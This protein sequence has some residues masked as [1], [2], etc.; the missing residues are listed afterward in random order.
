MKEQL[1]NKLRLQKEIVLCE[2]DP[3]YFMSTYVHCTH[4]THGTALFVPQDFQ[5]DYIST[6]AAEESDFLVSAA[7]QTGSSLSS[8]LYMFWRAFFNK[9][10]SISFT[11]QNLNHSYDNIQKIRHAYRCMPAWMRDTN[12][13]VVDNKG[14]LEFANGSKI[15]VHSSNPC[16]YRG[17]NL[18]AA[19]I[20]NFSL[21]RSQ[22][23]V[24]EILRTFKITQTRVVAV[25]PGDGNELFNDMF[26]DATKRKNSYIPYKL[27]AD[28][29]GI[30]LL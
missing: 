26:S 22:A 2:K 15:F 10:E 9:F 29:Y 14:C 12:P 6:L 1:L 13:M 16:S 4:P 23:D 7:R 19:F 28:I 30:G 20:D 25:A 24:S 11:A 3:I 18:T 17:I 27:V 8:T 5:E 21:I